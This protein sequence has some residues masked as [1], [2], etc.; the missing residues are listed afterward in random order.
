MSKKYHLYILS[1]IL[2]IPTVYG[3]YSYI[4]NIHWN[5]LKRVKGYYRK[6]NGR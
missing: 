4:F 6:E 5:I 3:K 1:V 2:P